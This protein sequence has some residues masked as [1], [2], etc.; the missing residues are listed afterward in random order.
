[1]FIVLRHYILELFV[2]SDNKYRFLWVLSF[3]CLSCFVVFCFV[4]FCFWLVET[5][6][7]FKV[8]KHIGMIHDGACPLCLEIKMN[9][10]VE[11]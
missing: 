5:R 6:K 4:L 10:G 11:L 7:C 9:R 8:L 3:V 2:V 1:M